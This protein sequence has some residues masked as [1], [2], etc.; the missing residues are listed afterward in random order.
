MTTPCE[1]RRQYE[2]GMCPD[3]HG[4]NCASLCMCAGVQDACDQIES[5]MA[6]LRE[7]RDEITWAY[8]NL[9][10]YC[11]Y[12]GPTESEVVVRIDAALEDKP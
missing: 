10:G 12:D 9:S 6:L 5:L 1:L 4:C 2:P 8:D 11:E 7:A 3:N